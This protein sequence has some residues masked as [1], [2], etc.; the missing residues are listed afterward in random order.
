MFADDFGTAL[1][2][3]IYYVSKTVSP[4]ASALWGG[5]MRAERLDAGPIKL[6]GAPAGMNMCL[7]PH[8]VHS[9]MSR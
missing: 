7:Q 8:Y 9:S 5:P 6:M 2:S 3:V 4:H 1:F